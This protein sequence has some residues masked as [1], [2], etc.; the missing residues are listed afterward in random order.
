MVADIRKEY[1]DS[2]VAKF[3]PEKIPGK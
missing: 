3:Y 1:A 2:F